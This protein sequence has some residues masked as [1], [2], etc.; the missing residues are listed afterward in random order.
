MTTR[1]NLRQK[2][3]KRMRIIKALAEKASILGTRPEPLTPAEKRSLFITLRNLRRAF[4]DKARI[5]KQLQD[6]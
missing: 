3:Y 4:E 5:E 2:H 1:Y 6:I